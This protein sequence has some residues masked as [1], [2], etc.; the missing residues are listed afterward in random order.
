MDAVDSIFKNAFI[1][2]RERAIFFAAGFVERMRT[3]QIEASY[4]VCYFLGVMPNVKR[5]VNRRRF[6]WRSQGRRC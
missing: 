5:D 1:A 4:T 2:H 6:Y 3:T